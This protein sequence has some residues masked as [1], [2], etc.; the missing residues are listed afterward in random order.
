M[1]DTLFATMLERVARAGETHRLELPA[2]WMQ[3]RAGFGGLVGALALKA[4]RPLVPPER[5]VRSLLISFVAPVGPGP[6]AIQARRLRSGKAVTQVETKLVQQ[7]G[8]CCVALGS[9]GGD[10]E[11]AI[12]IDAAPCPAMAG[13]SFRRRTE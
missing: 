9:F 8:I 5:K 11:S 7:D 12:R 13:F 10:R 2:D 1:P 4:M 6:F 3:G